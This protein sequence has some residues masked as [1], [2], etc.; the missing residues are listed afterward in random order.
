[1]SEKIRALV[2]SGFVVGVHGNEEQKRVLLALAEFAT[3]DG[4]V[5]LADAGGVHQIDIPKLIA[6]QPNRAQRRAAKRGGLP[7]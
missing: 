5:G 2:E 7:Q 1:M 3:D 6:A 4:R